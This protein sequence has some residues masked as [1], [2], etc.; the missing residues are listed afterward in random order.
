M[1]DIIYNSFLLDVFQGNCNTLHSYKAMLV[2]SGYTE[3]RVAHTKQSNI[4]NEVNGT[5]Y[6]AGGTSVTLS[7]SLNNSTNKLTLSITSP[8]WINSTISGVRKCI[9]YRNRGG[10]PSLN[11]LVC[12]IDNGT[13]LSSS[14]STLSFGS[15]TWVID[16][17]APT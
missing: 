4:T 9:I 8:F 17:P 14:N 10:G 5:G 15:S 11:E 12:C 3:D 7:V 6:S 13:D 1:A 2:S 16:L